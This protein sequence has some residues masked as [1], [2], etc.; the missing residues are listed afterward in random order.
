MLLHPISG[1]LAVQPAVSAAKRQLE[2]V[3]HHKISDLSPFGEW[4]EFLDNSRWMIDVTDVYKILTWCK[5]DLV[6]ITPNHSWFSSH[7]YCITH[8][9]TGSYVKASLVKPPLEYGPLS[10]WM[11][12]MEKYLGL[13]FIEDGSAWQ[14]SSD[15][16]RLLE[17]WEINDG[18]LIGS[19]DGWFTSYDRIMINV[20]K[21]HYIRVKAY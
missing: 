18:I 1:I 13:V 15:D 12:A 21:N 10:H 6:F 14:V 11:V 2:L 4:I 5:G 8:S 7:D 3:H 20:K 17:S 16:V 9:T 19:Y